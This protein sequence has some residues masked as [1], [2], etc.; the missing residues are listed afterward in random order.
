MGH[1]GQDRIG[2]G[3]VFQFGHGIG[4]RLGDAR[5]LVDHGNDQGVGR[6]RAVEF[7]Q[8]QGDLKPHFAGFVTKR[9]FQ[10]GH[11]R[12]VGA[13]GQIHDGDPA[14]PRIGIVQTVNDIF[15]FVELLEGLECG[16]GLG[17]LID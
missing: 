2:G 3:R 9:L 5:V 4:G 6:F 13:V 16:H 7:G 8:R 1:E 10:I 15:D 17:L 12:R 14:G 11:G